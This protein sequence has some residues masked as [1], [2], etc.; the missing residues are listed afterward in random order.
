MFPNDPIESIVC[1]EENGLH[2]VIVFD[3]NFTTATI[4]YRSGKNGPIQPKYPDEI[5]QEYFDE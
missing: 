2:K 3:H 5:V 4:N 1:G